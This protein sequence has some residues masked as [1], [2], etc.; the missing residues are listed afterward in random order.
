[1]SELEEAL[2]KRIAD[3]LLDEVELQRNRNRIERL[4]RQNETPNGD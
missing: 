2:R 4:D 1:M 3:V